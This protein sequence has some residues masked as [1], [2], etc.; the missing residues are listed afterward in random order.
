MKSSKLHFKYN[1]TLI[2]LELQAANQPSE[3]NTV[4]KEKRIFKESL[5]ENSPH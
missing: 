3:K 2:P 1:Y 4:A 5:P